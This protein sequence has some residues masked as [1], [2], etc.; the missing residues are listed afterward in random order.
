MLTDSR[1]NGKGR[2]FENISGGVTILQWSKAFDAALGLCRRQK[3]SRKLLAM[4]AFA[5][6]RGDLQ[7]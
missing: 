5:Q 3:Y 2:I 1:S 6:N 4:R 7:F